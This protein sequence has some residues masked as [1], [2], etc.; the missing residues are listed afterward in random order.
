[1]VVEGLP[2]VRGTPCVRKGCHSSRV[3]CRAATFK[4]QKHGVGAAPAVVSLFRNLP[5]IFLSYLISKMWGM[6]SPPGTEVMESN[7]LTWAGY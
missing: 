2:S 1:M 5:S 3:S 4:A 7:C 6:R